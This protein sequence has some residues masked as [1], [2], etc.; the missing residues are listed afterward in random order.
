ARNQPEHE[1]LA[2]VILSGSDEARDHRRAEELY[3]SDYLVKP[4]SPEDIRELIAKL[5]DTE[6]EQ[7]EMDC[8]Q[9][10]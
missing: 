4:A 8:E 7:C 6:W 5:A 9:S 3:A 10:A 2:V 1:H